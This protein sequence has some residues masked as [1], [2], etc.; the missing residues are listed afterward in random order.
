MERRQI[1]IATVTM[2]VFTVSGLMVAAGQTEAVVALAPA[3]GVTVQQIV[4]SA[5]THGAPRSAQTAD[6]EDDAP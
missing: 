3:L 1:L 2:A 4:H 6:K 5:R